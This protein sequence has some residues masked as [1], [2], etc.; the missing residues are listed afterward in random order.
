MRKRLPLR[1]LYLWTSALV[2][3]KACKTRKV[4]V[5]VASILVTLFVDQLIKKI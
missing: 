5:L 3:L 2:Y 4:M 1:L